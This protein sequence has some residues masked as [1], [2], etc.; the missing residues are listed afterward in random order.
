MQTFL[1]ILANLAG[2]LM[3]PFVGPPTAREQVIE[4][5]QTTLDHSHARGGMDAIV[6]IA[7][8]DEFRLLNARHDGGEV[9]DVVQLI[10]RRLKGSI[11]SRDMVRSLQ[12]GQ[13]ALVLSPL[14]SMT[15]DEVVAL[16]AQVQAVIA[17]PIVVGQTEIQLCASIGCA[18]GKGLGLKTGEETLEAARIAQ[19][20]AATHQSGVQL[21]T[22]EIGETARLRR[23]LGA[24]ARQAM[25]QGQIQAYFQ[26]QVCLNTKEI[27]G[28]EALARWHHAVRG[29]I[30]PAV[31]LPVLEEAGMMRML[32][33]V[34]LR[35]ALR[36]LRDWDAASLNV[37]RVSVNMS[38]EELRNPE[39]PQEVLVLLERY[40]L[41]PDRLVLEVLETV[42][43]TRKDDPII[44]NLKEL[45][46]LGC[47]IDLDDFGT[48]HTSI[49]SVRR[50]AV[51]RIKIDRSFVTGID[52]DA[53]QQQLVKTILFMADSLK[54]D[55]LAEGIETNAE[56]RHLADVGCS[57]GQGFAI[58]RPLHQTAATQWAKAHELPPPGHYQQQAV[59]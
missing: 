52:H 51:N 18:M 14:R 38:T 11:L 55:T 20:E 44:L 4:A 43:A 42:T 48:G 5:L 45:A 31:F 3:A 57:H 32:G 29:T 56:M 13:F 50:F 19:M 26:P 37:P 53:E 21:Y 46:R 41:T 16:A 28:F 10:E 47:Q 8:I 17:S 15:P 6:L 33:R 22:P 9:A 40:N 58:A 34:M 36:A 59:V 49:K 27:S 25:E 2:A 35:D 23:D 24:D 30:S 12:A 7:E 1:R 54:V 39:L